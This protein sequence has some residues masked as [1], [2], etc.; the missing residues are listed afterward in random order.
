MEKSAQTW[1]KRI[2]DTFPAVPDEA[3]HAQVIKDLKG[4]DYAKKL[5][6]NAYETISVKP[7]YRL[8]DLGRIEYLA[9][10]QPG[11]FPFLRGPK[12][13]GNSWLIRQEILTSDPAM[14]GLLAAD[15]LR[16]GAQALGFRSLYNVRTRTLRGV[17]LQNKEDMARLLA[18]IDIKNIPLYFDHGPYGPLA[19]AWLAAHAEKNAV[20]PKS[21]TGAL[22]YDPVGDFALTGAIHGDE[23]Q[24]ID[25]IKQTIALGRERLPSYRPFTV[26]GDIFHE[27]GGS[28]VE[29]I[30][31]LMSIAVEYLHRLTDAGLEAKAAAQAIGFRLAIG[32]NYFFEIAKLRAARLVWAHIAAAYGL[33][34]DPSAAMALEAVSGQWNK[35]LYDPDTN[36]LRLTSEAM[37][38]I[39]GGCRTLALLPHDMLSQE[40]TA[41][42]YRVTRNIQ[43][44]LRHEALFDKVAD[45][46]AGSYYVETL[47]DELAT[48]ALS[49]FGSWEEAGG[50]MAASRKGLIQEKIQKVRD[51]KNANIAGRREVFL[52][53]NQFPLAGEKRGDPATPPRSVTVEAA[54]AGDKTVAAKDLSA[55]YGADGVSPALGL[56]A[57]AWSHGEA[58]TLPVLMLERGA[59]AFEKIRL[60]SE[61][62]Q[63][64]RGRLPTVSLLSE[65]PLAMRIARATFISNF[66]GCAG[67]QVHDNPAGLAD[68]ELD[69]LLREQQPDMVVLCSADDEYPKL[70]ATYAPLIAAAVPRAFKMVAGHPLAH[71]EALIGMGTNDFVHIGTDAI[72]FFTNYQQKSGI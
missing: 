45:P 54:H 37:A 14:A 43:L 12:A 6:W 24:I 38:A 57:A 32:P 18:D 10:I 68:A 49:L 35:T 67:Y 36:I 55:L 59:L 53:T 46:S 52:G 2:F 50:F 8:S 23:N 70:M 3:W 72:A 48:R 17:A 20:D 41:F 13:E 30:A 7:Y 29:E 69:R 58:E 31:G 42:S 9:A 60:A 28:A 51:K 5:L 56:L 19:L 62:V 26:H 65:G 44:I 39:L 34:E 40:P 27:A 1:H 71:K 21:I 15:A 25:R 66:F 11:K 47:T 64:R 33:K 16:H 4:A 22:D 61:E 63:R